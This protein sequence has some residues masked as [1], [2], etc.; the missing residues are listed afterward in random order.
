[1]ISGYD[2]NPL[3]YQRKDSILYNVMSS[4]NKKYGNPSLEF[5]LPKIVKEHNKD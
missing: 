4:M 3:D 1:M 5:E 2:K